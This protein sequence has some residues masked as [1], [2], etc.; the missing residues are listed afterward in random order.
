MTHHLVVL[1]AGYAG[2]A[3]ASRAARRLHSSDVRIT[4][5]NSGDRF[6]ERIRLHQLA[7]GQA[8]REY[9]IRSLLAG[10]GVTLL[11]GSVQSID[12]AAQRIEVQ[13]SQATSP[14]EVDYDTL[15]FALGSRADV[16]AVPGVA[17]Y[18]HSVADAGSAIRLRNQLAALDAAGA[19]TVTVVGGGLTGIETTAELAESHPA[20]RVQVV[21]DVA[22]GNWLSHR[23][24]QHVHQAFDRLGIDVRSGTV[25][26]G[27]QPGRILLSTGEQLAADVIV[28]A[29]GFRVSE[30]AATAGFTVDGRGRMAVDR[31]LRSVSDPNVYGIGDAAAAQ[32]GDAVTRMCCQTSLPMGQHVADVIA[33][34]LTGRTP[35]P[36]RLRYV[37]QNISLGRRDAVTQFTH[38]D[39]SPRAATLR[40][41]PA[42]LFKEG[43]SRGVMVA[44]RH[45]GP[46]PPA[47]RRR[48]ATGQP[49]RGQ[50]SLEK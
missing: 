45:P 18:A 37:W 22:P 32:V 16:S 44:L 11:V 24:Q 5:I 20:L 4:L 7:A 31:T 21:N 34:Q 10:T 41:R 35:T 42:T 25:V 28:W 43:I 38:A 49:N 36:F 17:E 48:A 26:H 40:G 13:T 30:L 46:Y 12:A 9:P 33:D 50:E 23:A 19:G 15:V 29:A 27:V 8:L 39:D 14:V 47:V 1:G 3:A 6:V 2:L